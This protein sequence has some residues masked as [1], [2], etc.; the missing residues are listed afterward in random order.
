M[1]RGGESQQQ[2]PKFQP[3]TSIMGEIVAFDE[4][5]LQLVVQTY[6]Q[7]GDKE[8]KPGLQGPVAAICHDCFH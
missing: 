4:E 5:K 8:G 2:G 7:A 1:S 3:F 6:N